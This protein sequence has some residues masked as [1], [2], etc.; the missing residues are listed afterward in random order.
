MDKA[1]RI[2]LSFGGYGLRLY[3][4][5]IAAASVARM[6]RSGIRDVIIISIL[7]FIATTAPVWRRDTLAM[8]YSTCLYPDSAALHPGYARYRATRPVRRNKRSALRR[9][10]IYPIR[11][12][13]RWLLRPRVNRGSSTHLWRSYKLGG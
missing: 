2:H 5:Y 7:P 13:A 8:Y 11:R 3:P 9:M 12:N 4:P 6:Q 1:Q 10:F